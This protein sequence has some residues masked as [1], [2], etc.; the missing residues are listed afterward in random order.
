MPLSRHW[1]SSKANTLAS[2]PQDDSQASHAPMF[3]KDDGRIRWHDG[4]A[5]IHNRYRGVLAWPGSWT[6]H[7]DKVL[8]VHDLE[9]ASNT[10]KQGEILKISTEGVE[11]AAA[12]NSVLLKTVQPPN[13]AKMPAFDWA[14]GYGV[15]AGQMLGE[16][17][18]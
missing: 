4:A 6:H 3:T 12:E 18:G 11:V 15:K 5:A 2:E 9:P 13:K 10:G 17:N 1:L 8:K 14:N 16:P 7:K